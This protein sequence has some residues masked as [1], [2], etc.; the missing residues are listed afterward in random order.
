MKKRTV[1][2]YLLLA[3]A[4]LASCGSSDVDSSESSSSSEELKG[5][6]G[7][8]Y[9]RADLIAFKDYDVFSTLSKEPNYSFGYKDATITRGLFGKD[10]PSFARVSSETTKI[11]INPESVSSV[12]SSLKSDSFRSLKIENHVQ[13]AIIS[14]E[15]AGISALIFDGK[16]CQFDNYLA[17]G[18]LYCK[19]NDN[20]RNF[21]NWGM[22]LILPK[23]GY[24]VSSYNFPSEGVKKTFSDDSVSSI[25]RSGL[26]P[27]SES[28]SVLLP[29]LL[30]RVLSSDA[31]ITASYEQYA[32]K[33]RYTFDAKMKD[34]ASDLKEMA[35][36][37]KEMSSLIKT[38]EKEKI[39]SFIDEDLLPMLE[40]IKQS[41]L[42]LRL[43]YD[44][45]KILSAY[46]DFEV[47]F[48]EERMKEYILSRKDVEVGS[49]SIPLSMSIKQNT[50]FDFD[51]T[52]AVTFPDFSSYQEFEMPPKV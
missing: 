20:A 27:A 34:I 12:F 28:L 21:I 8:R 23:Y 2:R 5:D 19:P 30:E 39:Q 24:D 10:D 6:T 18:V 26:L 29:S 14:T 31:I 43:R 1:S 49:T 4:L 44:Q 35:D 13:K 36:S 11:S 7:Y 32:G 25:D 37:L 9:L 52:Q 15:N 45:E 16:E 41:D 22:K 42:A 50:S 3:S 46:V 17:D 40:T 51:E 48:D 38:E 47:Q 33:M